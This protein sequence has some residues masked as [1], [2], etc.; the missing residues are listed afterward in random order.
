LQ[1]YNKDYSLFLAALDELASQ[2]DQL[3]KQTT[4]PTT[5]KPTSVLQDILAAASQQQQQLQQ[6]ALPPPPP[7][8]S[9]RLSVYLSGR[10]PPHPDTILAGHCLAQRI[11]ENLR[12]LP[13]LSKEM[14]AFKSQSDAVYRALTAINDNDD[15]AGQ[16]VVAAYIAD[17]LDR[18]A[19]IIDK[20]VS[21]VTIEM[22]PNELGVM[23]TVLR[24]RPFDP[25]VALLSI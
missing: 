24:I 20:I 1:A 12:L 6:G 17:A 19:S 16:A 3:S 25:T 7:P 5:N 9:Q 2:L 18:E 13:I 15:K 14:Q 22:D 8:P 10:L 4:K 23:L 21:T 11:D